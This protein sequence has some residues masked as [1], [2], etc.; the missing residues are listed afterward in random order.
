MQRIFFPQL[1]VMGII[2]NVTV[3]SGFDNSLIHCGVYPF[4]FSPVIFLYNDENSP[5]MK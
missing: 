5:Y 3:V 1:T 2:M 4:D